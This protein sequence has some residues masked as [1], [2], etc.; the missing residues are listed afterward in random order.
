MIR[1]TYE[2]RYD[3]TNKVADIIVKSFKDKDEKANWEGKQLSHPFLHLRQVSTEIV[4]N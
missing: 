2:M 3:E 1:V 4:E